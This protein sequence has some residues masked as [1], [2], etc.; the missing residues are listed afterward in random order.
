[1]VILK[2]WFTIEEAAYYLCV[3]KRT[4][5]QLTKD[6]RLPAFSIGRER[7]RRFRKVDLDK[8]PRKKDNEPIEGSNQLTAES[9]PALAEVWDNERDSAYDR[10]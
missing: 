4:I 9:D 10:L 7:H 3:S 5:Y 6:G 2:E 8:V 1:M